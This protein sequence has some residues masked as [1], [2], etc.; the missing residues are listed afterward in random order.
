MKIK[1]SQLK[2]LIGFAAGTPFALYFTVGVY[3]IGRLISPQAAGHPV[4]YTPDV[5]ATQDYTTEVN[6]WTA[7]LAALDSTSVQL[8]NTPPD[9][10][11]LSQ[12]VDNLAGQAA[13]L[14]QEASLLDPPPA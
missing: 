6:Q 12:D 9:L 11:T 4:L 10:Y 8:L 1:R 14:D 3:L 5:V 13:Q 2:R 7:E